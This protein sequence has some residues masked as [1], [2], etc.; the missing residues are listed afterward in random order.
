MS[1]SK[2]KNGTYQVRWTERNTTTGESVR[3]A[4]RGFATK[5]EARIFEEKMNDVKE[6]SSIG[7]L[8]EQYI[9]SLKG[10]ANEET[11]KDKKAMA[12]RYLEPLYAFNTRDIKK[13]DI[14]SW[15]NGIA[16]LDRSTTVK[17]KILQLLKSISR[18]GSEYY[19]YPDFARFLKPFPKTSDDVK[20]ITVMSP[21]DFALAMD[22]INNEVYKQFFI[23][24]YHTGTRRG[25]A[26]GLLKSNVYEQDGKIY[27]KIVNSVD[28]RSYELK[29]LKNPQSKR[30]ILLDDQASEAIKTVSECEGDFVF[31]GETPLRHTNLTR[32]F[33][34]ALDAAGLPHYRI[35]DLRHSFISNAILN[36]VDIV[37]VSKYVGHNNIERTLNTYS[38]LL[39]DSESKMIDKMNLLFKK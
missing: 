35:H 11:R 6:F 33:N 39:K 31:G 34:K 2:D 8:K 32:Y 9:A 28:E 27:A 12:D 4:K 30:T 1:I 38:H 24:L 15:R 20:D 10:Y 17:N 5:R 37:T 3:K 26:Q 36:G 14:V 16:V 13:T 7:Q 19:E 21:E 22:Q 18:Y 29:T 25:E 23:F